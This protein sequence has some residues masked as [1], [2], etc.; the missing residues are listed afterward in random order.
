MRAAL[1]CMLIA[2]SVSCSHGSP[3]DPSSSSV[4]G[5]VVDFSSGAGVPAATVT[6]GE[7]SAVTDAGGTYRFDYLRPGMYEPRVDGV[8]IGVSRVTGGSYR[9][10]LLVHTGTCVARYG[11]VADARTRRPVAGATVRLSGQSAVTGSDGWFRI[12]LGCLAEGRVGF[13]TTDLAVSHPSYNDGSAPAGRGVV[14]T[15]R[16]DL[17]LEP[18]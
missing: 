7:T 15:S 4:S 8:W 5:R 1:L 2:A 16:F 6:F 17:D 10:D 9:G 3:S 13:N 14:G 12:D 18:R 11:T